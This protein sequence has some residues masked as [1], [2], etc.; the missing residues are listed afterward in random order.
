[1]KAVLVIDDIPEGLFTEKVSIKY[2][3]IYYLDGHMKELGIHGKEILKPMPEK[4]IHEPTY[5]AVEGLGGAFE[6][7]RHKG[8]NNCIDEILGG[9]NN[10]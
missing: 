2:Q 4:K 10:D 6:L 1:M 3:L 9:S 8:F 7:E 5:Y